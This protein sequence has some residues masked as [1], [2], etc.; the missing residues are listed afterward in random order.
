M[1]KGP[2]S[3]VI[4]DYVKEHGIDLIVMGTYGHMGL[5]HYLLGSVAEKVV[6]RAKMLVLTVPLLR[7]SRVSGSHVMMVTS[8]QM[9]IWRSTP[10]LI[11][12]TRTF[13]VAHA[14]LLD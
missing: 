2:A 8:D 4:L 11:A 5:R 1:T 14:A 9:A 12:S 6:R 7:Y 13:S 10:S 3:Q